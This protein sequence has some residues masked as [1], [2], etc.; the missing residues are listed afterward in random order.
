MKATTPWWSPTSLGAVTSDPARLWVMPPASAFIKGN[1]TNA[2]GRLPY[3][4]VLPTNYTASRAYPLWLNFHGIGYDETGITN[5][6]AGWPGYAQ[7][8]AAKTLISYRQQQ[9]DPV[10][11]LWPTRRAGDT[12]WTDAYLNQTSALLDQFISA[13]RCGHESDLRFRAV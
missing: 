7:L 9:R 13:V 2:L 12:Q 10:I 4:Y 1:F 5:P 3:F 6:I 11:L 8:C